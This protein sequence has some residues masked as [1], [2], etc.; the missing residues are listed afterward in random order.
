MAEAKLISS[1]MVG[2]CKLTKEGSNLLIYYILSKIIGWLLN[3]PL[4]G[5]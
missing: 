1:S 3:M 2:G 5:E 4:K